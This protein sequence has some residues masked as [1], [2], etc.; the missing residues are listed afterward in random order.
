M[1][2]DLAAIAAEM[3]EHAKIMY[4]NGRDGSACEDWADRIESALHSQ[5]QEREGWVS[6][7]PSQAGW[8]WSRH[9]IAGLLKI[10]EVFVR[11]GH[12]SLVIQGETYGMNGK[13]D[14]I[15]VDKLGCEWCGPI[16]LPAAPTGGSET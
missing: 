5:A 9:E 8:Y 10:V 2:P 3:R 14:Y 13:R 7:P 11:P 1:R 16:P 15:R 4:A 12:S 6:D